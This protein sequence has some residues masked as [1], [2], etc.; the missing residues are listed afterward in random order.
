MNSEWAQLESL[1]RAV[2]DIDKNAEVIAVLDE[3]Q[4]QAHKTAAEHGWW[5]EPRG[6][7][8][9]M[10][11]IATEL[12]EAGEAYRDHNPI[13]DKIAPF[14]QEEEELVDAVIRILDLCEARG[15]DFGRALVA[16]MA[17]NETRP[18]RHGGKRA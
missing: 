4:A 5:E 9:C 17:Y 15:F 1:G 18:H 3:L 12:A 13:S 8:E 10:M 6:D 7:L 2:M 11:L 16:K 14:S